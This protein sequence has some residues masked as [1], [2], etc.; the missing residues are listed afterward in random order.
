MQRSSCR[1]SRIHVALSCGG[2]THSSQYCVFIADVSASVLRLNWSCA[3]CLER[4]LT[5]K[6]NSCAERSLAFWGLGHRERHALVCVLRI[7]SC[8]QTASRPGHGRVRI[9][10]RIVLLSTKVPWFAVIT[11]CK[12]TVCSCE[13]CGAQSPGRLPWMCAA[14][15]HRVFAR[16]REGHPHHRAPAATT[17]VAE[18]RRE[19][20]ALPGSQHVRGGNHHII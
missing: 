20:S 2:V 8:E 17:R 15:P 14:R 7:P 9:S 16:C 3:T 11:P 19:S 10:A 6:L 12:A 1:E 13:R 4:S 5:W 18:A